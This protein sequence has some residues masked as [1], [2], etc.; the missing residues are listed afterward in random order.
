M[1]PKFQM[2]NRPEVADVL[3]VVPYQLVSQA[4]NLSCIVLHHLFISTMILF[5]LKLLTEH[6]III[7]GT[8]VHKRNF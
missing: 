6:K 5:P 7:S 8:S 1:S 2:E 3:N 4:V